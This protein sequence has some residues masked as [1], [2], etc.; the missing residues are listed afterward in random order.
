MLSGADN[1]RIDFAT[2][3]TRWGCIG[4]GHCELKHFAFK[5][6]TSRE[7]DYIYR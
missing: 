2:I 4:T 7:A 3:A 6:I 1:N 5:N